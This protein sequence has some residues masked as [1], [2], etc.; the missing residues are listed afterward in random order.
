MLKRVR[1]SLESNINWLRKK[2]RSK[3]TCK[4]VHGNLVKIDYSVCWLKTSGLSNNSAAMLSVTFNVSNLNFRKL[5]M[6]YFYV[7]AVPW[8]GSEGSS[9]FHALTGCPSASTIVSSFW[10]V[11]DLGFWT[12]D[13]ILIQAQLYICTVDIA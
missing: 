8:F 3:K 10:V 6:F 5:G 11:V 13:L 1:L 7:Q 4:F 12:N 9:G 2:V